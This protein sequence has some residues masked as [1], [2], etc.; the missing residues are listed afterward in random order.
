MNLFIFA[1]F[2]D[3]LA[4]VVVHIHLKVEVRCRVQHQDHRIQGNWT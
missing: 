3:H 2:K 4:R 1:F